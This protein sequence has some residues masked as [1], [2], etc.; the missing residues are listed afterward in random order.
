MSKG[1]P[2]DIPY[3]TGWNGLHH[4]WSTGT[5]EG[6][7]AEEIESGHRADNSSLIATT[8]FSLLDARSLRVYAM[9]DI[10]TQTGQTPNRVSSG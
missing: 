1:A 3:M 6:N 7:S 10:N 2:F 8:K 9:H 4:D 5:G